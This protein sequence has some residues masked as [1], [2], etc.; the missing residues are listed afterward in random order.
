MLSQVSETPRAVER[1]VVRFGIRAKLLATFG[2]VAGLTLV[3]SAVALVSYKVVGNSFAV[4][5]QD[6]LPASTS[7]FVLARQAADMSSVSSAL[8]AA[9]TLADAD[10]ADVQR[11]RLHTEMKATLADLERTPTGR[12]VVG[13]LR[14]DIDHFDAV[15]QKLSSAVH[16]R[17]ATRAKREALLSQVVTLHG[18]LAE[19]MAPVFDD[20][21]FNLVMGLRSAQSEEDRE[22]LRQ[23]LEALAE[24]E[25][26]IFEGAAELRS[27]I[28]LLVGVLNEIGQAPSAEMIRPMRDRLT[29]SISRA[30]R[31]IAKLDVSR[32][33]SAIRKLVDGLV[34]LDHPDNGI[35]AERLRELKVGAESWALVGESRA[36][37]KAVGARV[38]DA[39]KLAR[40][41]VEAQ[42]AHSTTSIET[43][44]T[45]LLLVLIATA[46][47]LLGA[48]LF[49]GST[50]LKRVRRLNDAIRA[51]AGGRHDVDVPVAGNDE[52]AEMGRAVDTFKANAIQKVELERETERAR[53]AAEAERQR[54]ADERANEAQRL[55][56]AISEVGRGL[57]ALA[58]G[59]L[60]YRITRPLVG[61]VDK[62]RV[63]FNSS[64]ETLQHS[65]LRI[66][67]GV[68]GMRTGTN[69]ISASTGDIARRTEQQAATLEETTA[70][71]GEVVQTVESTASGAH[72]AHVIVAR[73]REG[74]ERSG[75]VMREA[76]QAMAGIETSSSK[77]N[78]I[79]GVI[80]EIAFQTNLLALNAGVEAARAGEAGRGFAVVAS[81]VRALAQRS[82]SAAREI[83]TLIS[84]SADQVQEGSTLI[85][86]AEEALSEILTQVAEID[87]SVDSITRGAQDQATNLKG[88]NAAITEMDRA[89][90]QNAAVVEEAAA[91][92]VTLLHEADALVALIAPFR[93]GIDIAQTSRGSETLEGPR[94]T[95]P[96]RPA[97]RTGGTAVAV[98]PAQSEDNEDGWQD[99]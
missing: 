33:V 23:D 3:A 16:A 89:T 9:N 91:G 87:R 25:A 37:A 62:L 59:D 32:E 88:V 41:E 49:I 6:S 44:R 43:A 75:T 96:A 98:S 8:A 38:D 17:F 53:L 52:F 64:V 85:R 66:A 70:N 14:T 48:W 54:Y 81:E 28:N 30:K 73:T 72:Q 95:R 12:Q 67:E 77:I 34:A 63:D 84:T 50:V 93:L 74:A 80:D 29:A 55:Q 22:K 76:V 36:V 99:F 90:Q 13:A 24:K 51:L 92:A 39:V 56:I 58:E 1:T 2:V 94:E 31:S 47:A 60:L 11:G 5:E 65:L 82:A 68:Q 42:F 7:A 71:V 46:C 20:A 10:A 26:V 21:L 18:K 83:K 27:E 45:R 19:S 15:M 86:R 4:I 35:M 69:A 97:R 78:Q 79:I 40:A 57:S 61:D